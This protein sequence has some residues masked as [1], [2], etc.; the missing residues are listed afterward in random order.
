[1]AGEKREHEPRNGA[2]ITGFINTHLRYLATPVVQSVIYSPTEGS[3]AI[4]MRRV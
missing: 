4:V 3:V 2:H 1:M